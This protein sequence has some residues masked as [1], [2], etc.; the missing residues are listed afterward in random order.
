MYT[1]LALLRG[2]RDF[3]NVMLLRGRTRAERQEWLGTTVSAK[4]RPAGQ[5]VGG[6]HSYHGCDDFLDANSIEIHG[7]G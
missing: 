1:R 7:M 4:S 5:W 3:Y 2:I 6:Q